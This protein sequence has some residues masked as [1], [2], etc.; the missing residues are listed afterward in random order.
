MADPK[1]LQVIGS[2]KG[3]PG[4]NGATF[5]PAIDEE[6]NLS[7]TN[8]QGLENPSTVNL[9]GPKGDPGD[10]YELTDDDVQRIADKVSIGGVEGSNVVEF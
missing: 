7:W 1:K 3:E 9:K 8:D 4:Q 10:Q 5:K 2:L 6:G